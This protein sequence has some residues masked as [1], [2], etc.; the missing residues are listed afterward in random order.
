M[1]F[2]G[3]ENKYPLKETGLVARLSE[4]R[5]LELVAVLKGGIFDHIVVTVPSATA[6]SSIIPNDQALNYRL[7]DLNTVMFTGE[8]ADSIAALIADNEL[9]PMTVTFMNGEKVTGTWKLG[10]DNAKMITMTYLLYSTHKEQ[11][12]LEKRSLKLGER[13]KI[14]QKHLEELKPDSV[15]TK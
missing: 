3:W 1:I 9:N 7:E 8:K 13:L 14:V 5:Q 6:S 4:A 10:N 11:L 2:Q 15:P 12:R